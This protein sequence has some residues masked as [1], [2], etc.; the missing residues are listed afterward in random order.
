MR[1]TKIREIVWNKIVI[2]LQSI[3]Q[4]AYDVLSSL[5]L[6]ENQIHFI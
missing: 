6:D 1:V 4:N 5:A 2:A 3:Q